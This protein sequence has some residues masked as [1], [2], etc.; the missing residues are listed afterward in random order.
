MTHSSRIVSLFLVCLVVSAVATLAGAPAQT[1]EHNPSTFVTLVLHQKKA[2][3]L[4]AF[5]EQLKENGFQEAFPPEGV[6]IVSWTGSL[7]LGHVITLRLPTYKIP[8]VREVIEDRQWG[9]IEPKLYSSYDFEP[10]W[11]DIGGET[12]AGDEV[13]QE[14]TVNSRRML[15]AP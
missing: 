8:E 14:Y 15:I 12:N 4:V 5:K 11:K 9:D 3:S 1:Q 7:G 2:E 13:H 6:E 10:F